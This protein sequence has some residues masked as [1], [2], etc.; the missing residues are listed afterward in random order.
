[1]N[2]PALDLP[3]QNT[4]DLAV[5]L[6]NS[7]DLTKASMMYEEILGKFPNHSQCL[8]LLGTL[9]NQ[10]QDYQKSSELLLK[11]L[12]HD[13]DH[14]QALNALGIAF[15]RLKKFGDAE[16]IL[17]KA[18]I[19]N[20]KSHDVNFNLG[21]LYKDLQE[22][23]TSKKFYTAAISIKGNFTHSHLNLGF[24]HEELNELELALQSYQKVIELDP[25]Y[26]EAY[27]NIGNVLQKL[28]F[29]EEALF[30]Y[31][32]ALTISRDY[33][34]LW[35]NRGLILQELD[36]LE[37]S[38]ESF[39]Q[40]RLLE[41]KNLEIIN[42]TSN[43][44]KYLK[45]FKECY[46]LLEIGLK[47]KPRHPKFQW[48]LSILSLLLGD[49]ENGFQEYEWRWKDKDVSL[50][51]GKRD[52]IEPLWLGDQAIAGKTILLYS[53]QGLGDTIQFGRY[54]PL[55]AHLGCKVI[56]E[57]PTP[58]FSLFKNLPGV[59]H[60]V[61]RG[62]ALPPF[63]FQCPLMSLPLAFGTT[64]DTIPPIQPIILTSEKITQ[65]QSRI[66]NKTRPRAGL[67]WSGGTTHKEDRRRS[68][69]LKDYLKYC[70]DD[71]EYFSLQ[72]DV[73]ESDLRDLENS[74]ILHFGQE[75]HDFTDTAALITQLDVVITAD[76]SVAHLAASLNKPTLML[77]PF[78]PDWRWM[79]DRDDSPWYPSVKLYRQER[80]GE[81]RPTIQ[82][83]F[84][85]L[86]SI[87]PM[88]H[89]KPASS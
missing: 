63:D 20:P 35:A 43:I 25:K 71:F 67:V 1:M 37:E 84:D 44:Y 73:R 64:T 57:V 8:F 23:E 55:F 89:L 61:A 82:A 5:E 21:N 49:F 47:N 26:V 3:T 6:H 50:V 40:A 66:G 12:T 29:Y 18:L 85:D 24:L 51:S 78:A 13:P 17:K 9:A 59:D 52:F 87:K 54:V 74:T 42:N 56:L 19:L 15:R 34:Q 31:D 77:I 11:S 39:L 38:L 53:E 41:P 88:L 65:W 2:L 22:Y 32:Q 16:Q 58:L 69:P 80:L 30:I 68:I 46:E 79:L 76:T 45:K 33:Y 14:V 36:R 62:D 7:G 81:W 4:L 72:K 83:L 10:Q 28:K 75:L 48:N 27:I 70:T 60:L 86:S